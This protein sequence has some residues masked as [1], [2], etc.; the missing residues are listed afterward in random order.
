MSCT[1]YHPRAPERTVLRACVARHWPRVREGCEA[2]HRPLPSF[3]EREFDSYLRCGILEH[4]FARVYCAGCGHDRLVAFSCKGRGF[5]PS[6]GGRSIH[7]GAAWLCNRVL[8]EVRLR[9]WVLSLPKVLRYVL[10]YDGA[11]CRAV[12]GAATREIFHF[13]RM[14]AR[15]VLGLRSTRLAHV[16]ALVA[17]QLL[18]RPLAS[19][20]RPRNRLRRFGPILP[21]LCCGRMVH[22]LLFDG[23]YLLDAFGQPAFFELPAPTL[24]EL[25]H[26]AVRIAAAVMALLQRRGI[27]LG[28][29]DDEDPVALRN[30]A[31]AGMARAS[32]AGNL[33]FGKAGTKPVRLQDAR[34]WVAPQVERAGKAMGFVLD[35]E[36]RVTGHDRLHRERLCRYL[37]RPPLATIGHRPIGRNRCS[38]LPGQSPKGRGPEP[39]QGCTKPWTGGTPSNSR[40]PDSGPSWALALRAACSAVGPIR[41]SWRMVGCLAPNARLRRLIVPAPPDAEDGSDDPC[42]HSVAWEQTTTGRTIR[43]TW[44]PIGDLADAGVCHR[45]AG[46]P[47]VCKSHAAD[48][49]HHA[50]LPALRPAGRR[51]A[52][53]ALR[54]CFGLMRPD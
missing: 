7:E 28:E 41:Q 42:G 45:C 43:R 17:V 24:A 8:P 5:C 29:V 32:I 13:Q 3:V 36:V 14:Q 44:V 47:E 26:L 22:A 2:W 11:L 18:T 15:R 20:L 52:S 50:A 10:A 48:R 6:C 12:S 4:G 31:L 25:N 16:G 9:H 33:V 21:S 51:F 30:P 40:T 54:S 34:P 19:G 27:W 49:R 53:V 39:G 23:V 1:L 46:V 35:A 37:L 38:R